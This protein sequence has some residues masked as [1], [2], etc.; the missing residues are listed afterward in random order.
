MTPELDR[1]GFLRACAGLAACSPGVTDLGL[2]LLAP[3]SGLGGAR[4]CVPVA[5][6]EYPDDGECEN[7]KDAIACDRRYG[8]L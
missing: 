5:E 4:R 2:R 6:F 8:R 3:P 1:R 7:G